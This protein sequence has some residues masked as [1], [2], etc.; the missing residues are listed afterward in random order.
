MSLNR[1]FTLII[2]IP[3]LSLFLLILLGRWTLGAL[4]SD[5]DEIVNNQF[6]VLI[7]KQIIPMITDEMLP[8]IN[9]DIVQLQSLQKSIK[10]MMVADRD[11]NRAAIAEK[12]SLVASEPNEIT[13]AQKASTES[14]E[15]LEAS[16]LQAAIKFD[17]EASQAL[18]TQFSDALTLWKKKSQHVFVLAN[19]PGKLRF[20]RKASDS[21]SAFKAFTATRVII[22]E[23]QAIQETRIQ[24]AISEIDAKKQHINAQQQLISEKQHE[25]FAMGAAT[26][27]RATTMTRWFFALGLLAAGTSIAIAWYMA[28]LI[29]HPINQVVHGLK[30]IA[31]G[32]GDLT[33]RLA[34]TS[35]DEVGELSTWFNTFIAQLQTII[36]HINHNAGDLLTA[37]TGLETLSTRMSTDTQ[38]MTERTTVTTTAIESMNIRFTS[39]AATMEQATSNISMIAAATEE[40]TA[41]LNEIAQH[42]EQ[43]REATGIAVDQANSAS[44]EV[45]ELGTSAEEIGKVVE[46]ITNI[47]EQTKLLA[48]NATI[49]AARAGDAGKGF[50]VVAS[51][52]KELA[53]L[54]ARATQEIREKIESNQ[55]A[56]TRTINE[57]N[58]INRAIHTVN[59]MVGTIAAAVEEQSATT[60]EISKNVN[61]AAQG[62]NDV[63]TN[64]AENTSVTGDI[65]ADIGEVNR[66][67]GDIASRSAEVNT[68]TVGLSHSAEE[69][70]SLVDKF[71]V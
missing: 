28:R 55:G 30:E 42:S 4:S 16:M 50:A 49:E 26:R 32:D 66:L 41:S 39:V 17:T 36:N 47:S 2:G 68:S 35:R 67:M 31:E 12:M 9:R 59:E 33:T 40:M 10:A 43:A 60:R 57:I 62:V 27:D 34:I 1:K 53:E 21:G 24:E 56:A 18:Y 29:T 64:I 5:L 38:T 45:K 25:V 37:F 7:E 69:L 20:A 14:I 23:L 71:K 61:Q 11:L 48:L 58:E 44:A 8:L 52:I 46:T 51:E 65:A 70:K 13:A 3:I 22:G 6:T 63:N 15:H 19:T 54:T